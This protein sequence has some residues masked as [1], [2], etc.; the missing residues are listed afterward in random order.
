MREVGNGYCVLADLTRELSYLLVRAFQELNQNAEFIHYLK[1]RRMNRV[2][3]EISQEVGVSFKHNYIHSHARKKQ[4]QHHAGRAP[5]GDAAASV[6]SLFHTNDNSS[7][8]GQQI[9]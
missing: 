2:S 8:G 9:Y 5:S 4:S 1:R 3:A 6:N 7:C